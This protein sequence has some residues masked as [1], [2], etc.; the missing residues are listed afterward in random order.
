MLK[1][2]T[3]QEFFVNVKNNNPSSNISTG[4]DSD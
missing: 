2:K 3:L 1:S 4:N